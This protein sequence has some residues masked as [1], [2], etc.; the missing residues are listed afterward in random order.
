MLFRSIMENCHCDN[1]EFRQL[2]IWADWVLVNTIRLYYMAEECLSLQKKV[3][4]WIHETVEFEYVDRRLFA[5][6]GGTGLLSVYVVSPLIQRLLWEKFG[7]DLNIGELLFGIPL[8]R[9]KKKEIFSQ[10]KKIFALI[11]VT[12]RIKGQDILIQAVELLSEDERKRAEFWL[13]GAGDRKSV[14]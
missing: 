2:L 10:K 4:W 5:R 6:A 7:H 9:N 3:L 11:G 1:P 14:V 8:R 12:G 13:V